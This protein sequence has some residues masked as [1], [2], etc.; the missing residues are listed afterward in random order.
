MEEQR[1][2]QEENEN[3]MLEID[4]SLNDDGSEANSYQSF[5]TPEERQ[6]S[7]MMTM[8]RKNTFFNEKYVFKFTTIVW[9]YLTTWFLIDFLAC[10]PQLVILLKYTAKEGLFFELELDTT[11]ERL[12]YYCNL[13]R[14][15]LIPRIFK[16]IDL[17]SDVLAQNYFTKRTLIKNTSNWISTITLLF[18]ML[19]LFTSVYLFMRHGDDLADD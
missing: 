17:A 14:L 4:K 12:A 3:Y 13:F 6:V 9:N 7:I 10:V 5:K 18:L 11:I 19:H 2:L 16:A 8:K 15:F 1:K